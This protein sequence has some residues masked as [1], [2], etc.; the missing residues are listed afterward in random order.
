MMT[1]MPH[2]IKIP[3]RF[4]L[5]IGVIRL[6]SLLYIC[7]TKPTNTVSA[8]VMAIS[9]FVMV[10]TSFNLIVAFM[11]ANF[12]IPNNYASRIAV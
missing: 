3:N 7:S 2:S 1:P 9:F 12:A 10:S 6:I 4:S 11:A 8:R 5:I